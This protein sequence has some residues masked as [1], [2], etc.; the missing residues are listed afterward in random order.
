M[1]FSTLHTNTAI[2]AITRLRDMGVEPFLLSSS[3]VGILAQRLVRTLCPHCKEAY[4][5]TAAEMETLGLTQSPPPTLYR[6]TGCEAC[7]N[8][9]YRGRT[10]IYELIDVDNVLREMIH[11]GDGEQAM[12]AHARVTRPS[13]FADALRRVL[14]GDTS[15]EEILRVTQEK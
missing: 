10:G 3:M 12:E 7:N 13:M 6:P 15:V 9:G 4:Q 11:N 1:V 2:G 8:L 14:N 5:P